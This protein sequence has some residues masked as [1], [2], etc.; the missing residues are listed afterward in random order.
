MSELAVGIV[1]SELCAIWL[2]W[3]ILRTADPLILRVATALV[4]FI[5]FIGPLLAYW[6]ANFPD[7]HHPELRDDLKYSSNV[8]EKWASI[9]S[10]TDPEKRFK[11][12]R[13]VMGVKDRDEN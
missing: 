6:A 10:M 9:I 8:F 7:R 4:A 12:W 3:R 11:R 13:E 1:I 5:P 2:A